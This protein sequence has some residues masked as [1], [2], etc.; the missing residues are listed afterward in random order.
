MMQYGWD[1]LD[2]DDLHSGRS[3]CLKPTMLMHLLPRLLDILAYLWLCTVL[4]FDM[5]FL[6][7]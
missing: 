3:I 5:F 4:A 2:K 1:A 6:A 7:R